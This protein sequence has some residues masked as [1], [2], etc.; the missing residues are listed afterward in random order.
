[1]VERKKLI[2]AIDGK[3]V[4]ISSILVWLVLLLLLWLTSNSEG[5]IHYLFLYLVPF[6]LFAMPFG[7]VK[8]IEKQSIIKRF[9]LEPERLL[10]LILL[11]ITAIMAILNVTTTNWT[12]FSNVLLAPIPEEV[13][14]RGYILGIFSK[15][16]KSSDS[17]KVWG[18]SLILSAAIFSLSHAFTGEPLVLFEFAFLFGC[19]TGLIYLLTRSIL[20]PAAMHTAFNL[21]TSS[22]EGILSIRFLFWAA[23]ILLPSCFLLLI[24]WL[25]KRREDSL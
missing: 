8:F 9:G 2:F 3:K 19:L 20:L 4:L 13:F 7:M 11:G 21:L 22:G 1:M 24:E 16:I 6:Y 12:A 15:G 25:E 10:F 5:V 18:S 14:F 23:V 17:A